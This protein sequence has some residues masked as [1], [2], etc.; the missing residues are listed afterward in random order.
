MSERPPPLRPLPDKDAAPPLRSD[1]KTRRK[2]EKLRVRLRKR[3]REDPAGTIFALAFTLI[4]FLFF[5][6]EAR[7]LYQPA[8][9]RGD[10]RLIFAIQPPFIFRYDLHIPQIIEPGISYPLVVIMRD[11]KDP[12]YAAHM[13]VKDNPLHYPAFVLIPRIPHHTRW[14]TPDDPRFEIKGWHFPDALPVITSM[15]SIVIHDYPVDSNRLYL[16][17]DKSG[18]QGVYAFLENAPNAAAAAITSAGLWPPEYINIGT[19]KLRV[20]HGA[21]D[22]QAPPA[23][24]A[25]LVGSAKLQGSTAELHLVENA[26]HDL[27]RTLYPE[28]GAWRWL[29]SQS[30]F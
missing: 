30:R 14:A 12:L 23:L 27:A 24:A 10:H 15:I 21:H 20:Y 7:Y 11:M 22:N 26:G 17:G 13:L 8:L 4:L 5:L 3:Y 9:A 18:A 25:A 6:I 19:T 16:V 2:K 29:F 28:D 1:K